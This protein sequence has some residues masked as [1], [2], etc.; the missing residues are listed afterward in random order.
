MDTIRCPGRN[1][2]T[3]A[4]LAAIPEAK[5]MPCAACSSEARQVSSAVREGL[6]VR[7]QSWPERIWPTP[8]CA[9]VVVWKI[10]T[11]TEPVIGS[12]SCP[13]CS[14]RV[15]N[16]TGNLRVFE[17]ER[18]G[19]PSE[20]LAQ[21]PRPGS[22]LPVHRERAQHRGGAI[23]LRVDPADDARAVDQRQDIVAPDPLARPFVD[24]QGVVEAVQRASLDA[25]PDQVVEGGQEVRAAR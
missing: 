3:T 14:A 17:A 21:G 10:G 4:V 11:L 6:T 8:S 24:L 9:Y 16:S 12:G 13:A 25:I 20:C 19:Q 23:S 5:Q 1:S 15:S 22:A 2:S 18:E 7:A